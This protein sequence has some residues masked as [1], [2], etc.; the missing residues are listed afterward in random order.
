MGSALEVTS[1][2]LGNIDA[3]WQMVVHHC[4]FEQ[5]CPSLL[6]SDVCVSPAQ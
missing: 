6:A 3:D 1:R 4:Q 2:S 5:R